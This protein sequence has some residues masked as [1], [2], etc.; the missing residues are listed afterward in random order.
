M[1]NALTLLQIY[2][3]SANER[4]VTS[5]TASTAF[6]IKITTI[7]QNSSLGRYKSRGVRKPLLIF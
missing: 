3:L 2:R 5:R 4:E 6:Q 1:K 7:F